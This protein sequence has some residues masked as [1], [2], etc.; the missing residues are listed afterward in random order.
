MGKTLPGV[1]CDANFTLARTAPGLKISTHALALKLGVEAQTIRAGYCR[2]GHYL[3]LIPVV[4]P[5]GHLRWDEGDSD[6]VLAGEAPVGN[7]LNVKP[8]NSERYAKARAAA[9]KSVEARR[10]KRD[11]SQIELSGGG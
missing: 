10:A 6:R 2:K 9:K 7:N 11:A 8:I 1:A 4:L 5:N 3:G